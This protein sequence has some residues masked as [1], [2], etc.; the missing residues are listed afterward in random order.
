MKLRPPHA[1]FLES[2]W[3]NSRLDIRITKNGR[4]YDQKVT[5]DIMSAICLGIIDISNKK[6]YFTNTD[7]RKASLFEERMV[8][9]FGKPHPSHSGASS[10][11][12]KVPAQPVNVLK[13]AGIINPGTHN[14]FTVACPI[15]LEIVEDIANSEEIACDF[16]YQYIR[17]S[18]VQSGMND[19]FDEFFQKEDR[20]SFANLKDEFANFVIKNTPINGKTECRRIFTKVLNI[21]SFV[22]KKKG[23]KRGRLSHERINLNDIRYNRTNWR[24]DAV[25]KPKNIPRQIWELNPNNPISGLTVN[26]GSGVRRTVLEV[27]RHHEYEPEIEDSRYGSD[28]HGRVQGHHIF[29]KSQYPCF[30]NKRENIILLTPAQHVAEAHNGESLYNIN[31]AYQG[32]CLT[33]KLETIMECENDPNCNFY[34]LEVFKEMLAHVGILSTDRSYKEY[35]KQE[36]EKNIFDFYASKS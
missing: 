36:I 1:K 34:S 21:Q 16:L 23:T 15:A 5:P 25:Q 3:E 20:E 26:V 14:S 6:S 4:W 35:S 33:Q 12:D 13:S 17:E 18:L 8:D 19:L 24:D 28:T 32:F 10:E 9:M 7:I 30:E 11:Y 2:L 27:K 29:P 22:K 31:H